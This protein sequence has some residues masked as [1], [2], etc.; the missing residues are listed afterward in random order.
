MG[1]RLRLSG[2]RQT[3]EVW[4]AEGDRRGTLGDLPCISY[5]FVAGF[6]CLPVVPGGG[7]LVTT[8][9]VSIAVLVLPGYHQQV[10]FLASDLSSWLDLVDAQLAGC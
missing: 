7:K 8:K 10:P 5:Y 3:R 1:F 9:S 4:L 6:L 2:G